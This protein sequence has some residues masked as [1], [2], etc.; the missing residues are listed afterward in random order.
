MQ[1]VDNFAARFMIADERKKERKKERKIEFLARSRF[2]QLSTCRSAGLLKSR[3][4]GPRFKLAQNA[5]F[6]L[7]ECKFSVCFSSAIHK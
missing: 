5:A 3:R 1:L 7:S 6:C 2:R 4:F